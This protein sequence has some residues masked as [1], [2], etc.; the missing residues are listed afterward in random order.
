MTQEREPS[1]NDEFL[2]AEAKNKPP[3]NSLERLKAIE[4]KL[5]DLSLLLNNNATPLERLVW[6]L[7][8]AA[9]SATRAAYLTDGEMRRAA[10]EKGYMQVGN[11]LRDFREC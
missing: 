6:R 8:I 11:A 7:L 2:M 1:W 4:P 9:G 3:E 5:R 10:L